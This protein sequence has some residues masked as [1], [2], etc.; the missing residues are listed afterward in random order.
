MK[1]WI[2]IMLSIVLIAGVT[3]ASQSKVTESNYTTT[4]SYIICLVKAAKIKVDGTFVNAYINAAL[5]SGI[6]L[7]EEKSFLKKNVTKVDAAVYRSWAD[8]L[9]NRITFNAVL[10][11]KISTKKNL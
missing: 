2:A 1:K 3:P 9:L 7:K 5:K 4:R 11:R 10:C 6:L 8:E